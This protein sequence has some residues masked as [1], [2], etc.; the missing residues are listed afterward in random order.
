MTRSLIARAPA[1]LVLAAL[2][3]AAGLQAQGR[4]V[5]Q[6]RA[7]LAERY[8]V[9]PIQR[10]VALVPRFDNAGFRI[11]EIVDGVVEVDG[12]R[13]TGRELN[14][15][16]RRDAELMLQVSYLDRD[17]LAALASSAGAAPGAGI[18]LPAPPAPPESPEPPLP[19][20]PRPQV[21]NGDLV[22]IGG[23]VRVAR[24]ERVEGDVVVVMG[25]ADIDGE[26]EG[27][28]TVVM[29]SLNLG[30]DAVVQ[31]NVQ[32]V[33][34]RLNRQPGA[35]VLGSINEVG[36]GDG[37]V[38]P[39]VGF[40]FPNPF[41]AFWTRVG[42][43]AGTVLRLVLVVLLVLVA[44]ALARSPV[45][46][47][48]ART[49]ADPLR[50]GFVGLLAELLF[51]PL[52]VVVVVVLAVSIVGIPLLAL[53]PFG[54]VGVAA[55]MVVGFA[56]LAYQIGRYLA[57]R[58]GWSGSTYLEVTVGVVAIMGLTLVARL[59]SLAVGSFV[60]APV[61][62]LG[63]AVEYVAWT[64]GFGATLLAW[65]GS[66]RPAPVAPPPPLPAA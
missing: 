35:R 23:S 21:R 24:D 59:A 28:V 5:E 38:R 12:E 47:I 48:A 46:L 31:D 54:I 26:V 52:L 49:A 32:V 51:I 25:S 36:L 3:A 4:S 15:R 22:R 16:L 2:G 61:A 20:I 9:A 11:V 19:S 7:A 39:S 17:G 63:Y 37:D 41:R 56:G 10:G 65:F 62:V 55:L 60:G 64:V 30:P 34:G 8:S 66:R 18:A 45:E 33:G 58:L 42:N 6:L 50:S 53:V 13:L 40:P 29:G 14:D 1:L 44:V 57:N 43:F 27:E